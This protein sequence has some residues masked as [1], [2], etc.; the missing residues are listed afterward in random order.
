MQQ[1]AY[2]GDD[3]STTLWNMWQHQQ[4]AQQHQQHQHQ[5]QQHQQGYKANGVAD[6][7]VCV[8]TACLPATGPAHACFICKLR[9]IFVCPLTWR[10]WCGSC[11][12]WCG[13]TAEQTAKQVRDC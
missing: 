10:A 13:K 3:A 5:H 2:H 11:R 4:L 7:E 8:L 1:Q 9:I 6:G 12:R